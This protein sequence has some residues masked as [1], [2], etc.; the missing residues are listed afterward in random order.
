M[1]FLLSCSPSPPGM[2]WIPAGPFIMGSDEE[3]S[4]GRSLELGLTKPWFQ[5]EK[6]AHT[7]NLPG[8]YMDRYE[9]SNQDFKAFVRERQAQPPVS[10]NGGTYPPGKDR[11]PVTDVNWFQAQ[12]YC[13][14]AAKRLPTEAEWEKAARGPEGLIY[15]WRNQFDPQ[16]VN[17]LGDGPRPVGSYPQGASPYHVED[18]IG[19]VWEW[20][21]DSYQPYPGNTTPSENYNQGFKVIRGKSWT[22]GFGHHTADEAQ[23][24]VAHE[25]RASYRLYFDPAFS[26]GDLG[27]RC[28]KRG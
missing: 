1:L 11:Y 13:S 7:V 4:E 23:E 12:A 17:L 5:D 25:A 21:A 10:W 26:F 18:L 27:F 20:T 8:F 19:N 9:V 28:A 16:M 6:P 24:I 3:D 22:Q 2:I 15:P 14:W